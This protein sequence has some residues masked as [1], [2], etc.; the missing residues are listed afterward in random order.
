VRAGATLEAI[1]AAGDALVATVDGAPSACDL[2]VL[3]TGVAPNA[4]LA[5]DAGCAL[6]DGG[7]ILVDRRGRTTVPGIWAAGDCATAWHRVLERDV[8]LP[9]AT[10]ATRQ[11]RVAGRDLAG[12][13]A[14]FPGVLGSWVS[15]GFGVGFG[16]T[17]L[18]VGEARE[19]GFDAQAITRSGRD[20][21][22]YI[23]GAT[24]I[25]VR[26]VWDGAAGRLLG[27]QVCGRGAV[28]TRLHTISTAI[29][30]GMT[31]RDLADADFGYV[32]PLSALRDP[33]ELA[34]AAAVG[35]AP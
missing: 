6:G 20:R 32:P 22:G 1:E 19:A 30:A 14:T 33:I 31:I 3:G 13:P 16:A 15:T 26:L 17:G 28:S 5:E 11:A 4:E 7:A 18:E 35:D 10:T 2:V 24:E 9:L 27:G 29:G 25:R 12:L 21:S 23:P 8:W 34:A